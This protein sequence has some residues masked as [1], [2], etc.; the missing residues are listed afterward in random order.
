MLNKND[1]NDSRAP[2]GR[3]LHRRGAQLLLG[4]V[5]GLSVVWASAQTDVTRTGLYVSVPNGYPNVQVDDMRVMSTA[6]TA[7]WGR[8]WSG[9]EWTF[10]SHWESLSQ[11]WTNLTGSITG[12][13]AAGTSVSGNV[14]SNNSPPSDSE[15][16]CWVWVDED[17]QPSKGT[18]IVDDKPIGIPMEPQRIAP[19]NKVMGEDRNDYPAPRIVNI[20]YASLCRGTATLSS[21]VRDVE[22]VRLKNELYLGDN[23]R[24]AFSNRTTLEKRAVRGL[25]A[26]AAGALDSSL[27]AGSI[28][29]TPVAIAKGFRWMDKGGDW[30]DYNTQGQ[31]VAYGDRNDNTVWM[32][33]DTAGILRGVVDANGRV[34]FTLHYN[35]ALV[36][37]VRDYPIA[38]MP[39]DLPAR[40]VK[41]GYD[42]AFRLTSVIDVRGN[43][44]RYGYDVANHLTSITDQEGRVE[45]IAYAGNS[46]AKRTAPDGGVTDYLFEFDDV[47]KQFTSRITGPETAAGRRVEEFTHNRTGQLVRRTVNGRVDEEVRYDT[48]ARAEIHTDARGFTSR[49]VKNEFDQVVES[50]RQDGTAVKYAF[51]ALNLGLSQEVNETGVKTLYE[52]DAKGNLSKQVDAVGSSNERITLFEVNALG[53]TTRSTSK[54]RTEPNGSVTRDAVTSYTYDSRGTVNAITD[55]EANTVRFAYDRVGNVVSRTDARGNA[56]LLEFDA[57]GQ[58]LKLK[59]PMGRTFA[60]A[61]DKVG[62]T[63][64]QRDFAGN[65][66]RLVFNQM[67][68]AIQGISPRIGAVTLD[69]DKQGLPTSLVDADGGRSTFEYDNFQRPS[70]WRDAAGNIT[71]YSY[72]VADGS[73]LGILGSLGEPTEVTHPT[74]TERNRFDQRGRPTSITRAGQGI[75]DLTNSIAYGASGFAQA[76]TNAYG[77]TS[78]VTYNYVGLPDRMTDML[79]NKTHLQYDVRGNLLEVLDANNHAHRYEYDRLGRII[80]EIFPLGQIITTQYDAAGNIA[81]RNNANGTAQVYT[82]DAVDRL[83]QVT[84]YSSE[85]TVERT[86]NF[87]WGVQNELLAWIDKVKDAQT[88]AT[89]TYDIA[90]RK[91]A[92]TVTYP[93]GF[94]MGY[95]YSYNASGKKSTITWP[96]NTEI[97]YSY[98]SNGRLQ[99]VSIPGE[100]SISI[101]DYKWN[102]PA[103]VTLP[104]GTIQQKTYDALLNLTSLTVKG[105]GQQ[106]LLDTTYS[107][108]KLEELR[109]SARTDMATGVTKVST[110]SYDDENRLTNA[111]VDSGG[112]LVADTETF[113]LDALANRTSDSREIGAWTHDANDRLR[114]RGTGINATTYDYDDAGNLVR[115]SEPA[116]KITNYAYDTA[117]RLAAVVDG[118]GQL[119]ARYGYDPAGRRLWKEQFRE[120]NGEIL[121][122]PRRTYYL[123]ADEGL[124]AEAS[125]TFGSNGVPDSAAT[126]FAEYGVRPNAIFNTEI[127]FIKTKNSN[128]QNV[129]AY[130]HNDHLGT[131]I[132]ASDRNGNIVWAANYDAFGK[133]QITTPAATTQKPT[134]ASNLRFSGQTEDSE[135][136]WYY[137]Y[138]R[139]YD[140]Q[141]GRYVQSDPIGL[142]GGLNSYIYAN[143]NPLM[144][145]DPYGLLSAADLPTIPQGW[146][147]GITGFGDGINILGYSPSKAIR[148]GWGI[149]GGVNVCSP[150][151]RAAHKAGDLYADMMPGVGRI[152][153]ITRIGSIPG[154]FTSVSGA[155]YAR[156]AIKGEYRSIMRP[157]INL[158]DRDPS[159]ATILE[160]A[161]KYGDAYAIKRAA[162]ANPRWSAG[163]IGTSVLSI[164]NDF[165][166]DE[167]CACQ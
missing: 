55:P 18:T 165:V 132:Q 14:I 72:Q 166:G 161:A 115:M 135:T 47:N 32:A 44:T 68:K 139:D 23:G 19:F 66:T 6:G 71:G 134:I 3:C 24:Y 76:E 131:P 5:C 162:K 45:T 58:V 36:T 64:D 89:I 48:G 110:Y 60:F 112:I 42:A 167:D 149:S 52:Y 94:S 109:T 16:G 80:K 65:Q 143:A 70:K 95:A 37:E 50:T 133:A 28:T 120:K 113:T 9:K 128:Q 83:T 124:L 82:Y 164:G 8:R 117:H 56:T 54:G 78:S 73:A 137:N 160:K 155:Y 123:Y 93:G 147:D 107:Y 159:L 15:A 41:Y 144:Y 91:I 49:I 118:S 136:G 122:Q 7:R 130:Y 92:E 62:N 2:A 20:D 43:T 102:V 25:P 100:G 158:I 96:D 61:Y 105:P 63:I 88:S 53:Q 97:G 17:W 69:Y 38:G 13:S 125:Q 27:A 119:I 75:M 141:T 79:G 86:V 151:Y 104:G 87:T 85:N 126:I 146:V 154:K 21:P 77:K 101:T 148:D 29:L 67:D 140:P 74:F 156:K 145:S 51:S 152:G 153:Y 90:A 34:M 12:T 1:L 22:A 35:G 138:Y 11:S 4:L 129:V 163:V 116:G 150:E 111:T 127:L 46:V 30:I 98:G 10:N 39:L 26:A 142:A 114:Q 121:A 157:I 33:R 81:A 40:S 57:K 59:D 106:A 31:V 99:S 108:G 84:Y 103:S